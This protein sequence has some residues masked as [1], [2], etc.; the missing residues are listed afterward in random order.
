ME[1]DMTT[2]KGG[3]NSDID[4]TPAQVRTMPGGYLAALFVASFLSAL[5]IYL[6]H[7]AYALSIAFASWT[8]VPFLW[9]TDR[10]VFDGRRIARTG[11][12]PRLWAK[13]TGTRDRLRI[14]D[15]E[16]VETAVFPGVK[17]GRNIYYTYRTTISG[18][19]ARFVFSSGH[20]GYLHMI[21][22][23]LPRVDAD[24]LDNPSIDLRDYLVEKRAL[25]QRAKDSEIPSSDVLDGSFRDINLR[26]QIQIETADD[27]DT[28]EKA[29]HLRRLANELRLSGRLFQAMEAFRRAAI[30]R[31]RDAHLL[32]EFAACLRSVAGSE[33]DV[34]LEHRALAMMRLAE[35]HAG[36]DRDLLTRIGECYFQIGE[37]HRAAIVFKRATDACGESFR[38]LCG[39]AEVALREGKL[40]HVIHN[41]SAA[42][43]LAG[44]S[45]L[46]RWTK[47]EVDYFSHLNADEEYMELEISRVNLLDTLEK[48]K[49]SSIRVALVGFVV[50][51]LGLLFSDDLIANIGWAVSGLSQTVWIVAILMVKMLSPRIPFELMETDE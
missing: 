10:I 1:R 19:T 46:R 24:M 20:R 28:G 43:R 36:N 11:L 30:L 38:M 23:L 33:D 17:R 47:T 40:A 18:K 51:T 26:G 7:P 32:F 16:Q 50:I 29:N 9:L 48:T 13:A 41:F 2:R 44:T 15:I 49:R 34:K 14:R 45:A 37:W 5:V 42:N 35:R 12:L 3:A 25:R 22:S 27:R 39:M 31:P 8:V 21:K 4:G 6:D